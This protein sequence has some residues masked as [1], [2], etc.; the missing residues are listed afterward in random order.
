[1]KLDLFLQIVKAP[2]H[3]DLHSTKPDKLLTNVANRPSK[4]DY[5]YTMMSLFCCHVQKWLVTK[6]CN[7][8]RTPGS[9]VL[10]NA[11]NFTFKILTNQQNYRSTYERGTI[12][13]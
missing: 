4:L 9:N 3:P 12:I 5:I 2:L 11:N 1:M 6:R 10:M 8:E 13:R 7:G